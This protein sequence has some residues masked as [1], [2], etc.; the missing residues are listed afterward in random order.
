MTRNMFGDYVDDVVFPTAV[1]VLI[2]RTSPL[3]AVCACRD[4]GNG[5]VSD[6]DGL[7]GTCDMNGCDNRGESPCDA[8]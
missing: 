3:Y 4:C 7:C 2:G 6:R 5:P 8:V 1:D